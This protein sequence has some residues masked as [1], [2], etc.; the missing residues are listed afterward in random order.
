LAYL[1]SLILLP[2]WR[3][4]GWVSENDRRCIYTDT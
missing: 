3:M 1:F 2:S 4:L